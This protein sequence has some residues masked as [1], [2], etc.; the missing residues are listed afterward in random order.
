MGHASNIPYMGITFYFYFLNNQR[1]TVQKKSFQTELFPQL[2][3]S[4]VF[5][6][7]QVRNSRFNKQTKNKNKNK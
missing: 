5:K 3:I 7:V 2:S 1:S 6:L 4:T